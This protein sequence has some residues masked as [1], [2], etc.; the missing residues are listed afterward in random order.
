MSLTTW[1]GSLHQTFRL[2]GARSR[3]LVPFLSSNGKTASEVLSAL[4][5]DSA[6]AAASGGGT[7]GPDAKRYRD[8]RQVY[9]T[10]GLVYEGDDS[11]LRVTQLGLATLRWT[12]IITQSNSVIL[13]RHAAY[14][15]S[16]CQLRTPA[17][18]GSRYDENMIVFPFQFIWKAML[19][20]NGKI[21]SD[22]LNREIFR[23]RNE[24]DLAESIQRIATARQTG[25]PSS[26]GDEV[27]TG[28]RKN[29][30]IIPWLSLA[31]FGWTLFPDKGG[32]S[33][34]SIPHNALGIIREASRIKHKH[35]E[36]DSVSEYVEY[37]SSCACLPKDLR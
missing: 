25:D 4:P 18:S 7:G 26:L 3:S 2:I 34:Y 21:A 12:E 31:S 10:A 14:A 24:G 13:G 11:R 15:L 27:I 6:R 36:F 33:F 20:L 28:E 30:R 37:L 35:R 29:D 22:E 23:T 1:S 5:Y 9:Q 16:A 8:A 19:A 32:D 17:V